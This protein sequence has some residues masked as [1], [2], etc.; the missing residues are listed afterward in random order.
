MHG[1]YAYHG[2]EF[3]SGRRLEAL[4]LIRL[5]RAGLERLTIA[6]ASDWSSRSVR[7]LSE[8]IRA[9]RFSLSPLS[10]LCAALTSQSKQ[11]DKNK[12]NTH[13]YRLIV[14][15]SHKDVTCQIAYSTIAGD[16]IVASAYAHELPK[17]GLEVGLTNYSA[18]YAVGLLVARRVLTK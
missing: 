1:L 16:V 7:F 17:Y 10:P 11:Q 4:G 2:V 15:F 5:S 12:Y 3:D 9:G 18:A 6:L 14:R 13:K 8:A